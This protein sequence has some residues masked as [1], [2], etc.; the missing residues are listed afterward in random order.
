MLME[1]LDV[2]PVVDL[3]LQ[4]EGFQN[5]THL[6][7]KIFATMPTKGPKRLSVL[8]ADCYGFSAQYGC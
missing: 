3:E 8:F 7:E 2:F 1:L 5:K 4:K 6:S